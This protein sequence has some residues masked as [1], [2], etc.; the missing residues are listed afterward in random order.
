LSLVLTMV[1]AKTK[2]ILP[3]IVIHTVNNT[4]ASLSLLLNN[5]S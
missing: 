3:C 1:R 4:V 5:G 2:S